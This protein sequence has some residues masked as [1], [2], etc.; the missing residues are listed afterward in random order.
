MNLLWLIPAFVTG[1]FACPFA[2]VLGG[3]ALARLADA[4]RNARERKRIERNLLY[5]IHAGKFADR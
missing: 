2:C 1:F 3:A 4:R 5:R